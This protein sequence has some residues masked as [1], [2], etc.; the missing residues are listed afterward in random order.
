MEGLENKCFGRSKLAMLNCPTNDCL[1]K[2]ELM[3][4]LL[5]DPEIS[6]GKEYLHYY[7]N[8]DFEMGEC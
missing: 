1:W 6:N 5:K 8:I 3:Q 7:F 2:K 4:I